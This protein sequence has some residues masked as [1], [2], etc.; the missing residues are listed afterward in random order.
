MDKVC[1]LLTF[2][3][4]VFQFIRWLCA[5]SFAWNSYQFDKIS[6][7]TLLSVYFSKFQWVFKHKRRLQPVEIPKQIDRE[8]IQ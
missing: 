5:A 3:T 1:S 6:K 7:G 4:L 8:R 2:K